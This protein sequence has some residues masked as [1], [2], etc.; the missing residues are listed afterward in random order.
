M[1]AYENACQHVAVSSPE[2]RVGTLLKNSVFLGQGTSDEPP[3]QSVHEQN[4][5]GQRDKARANKLRG[6]GHEMNLNFLLEMLGRGRQI[7]N[8]AT[9]CL[10]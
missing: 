6:A 2:T 8:K 10:S 4:Q 7:K 5:T 3:P 1:A 9:V